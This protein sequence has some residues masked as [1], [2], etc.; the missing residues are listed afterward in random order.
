M[1]TIDPGPL[2]G[3]VV[4]ALNIVIWDVIRFAPNVIMSV[5][6]L[7]LGYFLSEIVGRII[8]GI[9]DYLKVEEVLQKYRVEDAL[10]GNELSPLLSTAAKWYVMLLFLTA[11][12]ESLN[13]SSIN[14]LITSALMFAPVLIG[15]GLLIIVAAIIGEWIREAILDLHKFYMQKT[16]AEISKWIVV[17]L[18]VVVALET[19][20][21]QMAFVREIFNTLLQGAVYGVAIA[22]GLAFGLGGQKDAQDV[23]RKTRKRFKV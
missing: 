12:I 1:T 22:F 10:G 17:I 4:E 9:L 3:S 15:V 19:I 8:S 21:F 13:L 6:L 18:S 2:A 7:V 11:A 5:A 20:G 23:I 14:W 16:L